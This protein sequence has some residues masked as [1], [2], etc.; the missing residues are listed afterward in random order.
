MKRVLIVRLDAIGDYILWR[1]CLRFLRKSEKYR[2]VHLTVLGNPAWRGIAEAF[3]ADCAD[4]WIWAED[5]NGLFRKSCENLLPYC[6][7]HRRVAAAQAKAKAALRT[8]GF[9]E[10]VSPSA[11]PDSLLDEFVTGIAPVTISVENGDLGRRAKFSRLVSPGEEPFVFLHNKA[12][13]SELAGSPCDAQFSLDIGD[14]HKKAGRI[15]F[16]D[17]AS[18]WT[19]R[20]PARRWRE[21][22]AMLPAGHSAVFAQKGKSLSDFVRLAASCEAVVSNDTMALHVA[23]A[24]G[25]PA[26]AVVNGVSGKGSFWP[27]PESMG[28]RVEVCMPSRVPSVPIPLIGSRVAQYMALSSVSARQVANALHKIMGIAAGNGKRRD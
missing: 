8:R 23:A 5:R 1:N 27:Y 16:F 18:H 9:D 11:F 3:D 6:I 20:W 12:I 10:V 21:L 7:W 4:E 14:T 22:M 15:L 17:G 28:K 13:A 24:L 26:V 19:R 25:V 2:N